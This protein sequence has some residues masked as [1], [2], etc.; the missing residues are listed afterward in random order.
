[1]CS[2]TRGWLSL[3]MKEC[4]RKIS[5][6]MSELLPSPTDSRIIQ[7][8]SIIGKYTRKPSELP[9]NRLEIRIWLK[10]GWDVQ[11]LDEPRHISRHERR[12][13]WVSWFCD[14][15]GSEHIKIRLLGKIRFFEDI[16]Q[17]G[18]QYPR[19]FSHSSIERASS[20]ESISYADH[21]IHHL[22]RVDASYR[23]IRENSMEILPDIWR[24]RCFS[25]PY[26][27]E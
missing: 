21:L 22:D 20:W 7:I 13:E 10:K 23:L 15:I 2:I 6:A 27:L 24:R 1:M 5:G 18:K 19:L 25:W 8:S 26:E 9:S 12:I 14:D 3:F 16:S 4:P 17:F 11:G